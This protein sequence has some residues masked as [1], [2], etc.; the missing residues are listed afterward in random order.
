MSGLDIQPQN[1]RRAAKARAIAVQAD[2]A[3]RAHALLV[4]ELSGATLA[5]LL[6]LLLI[7]P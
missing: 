7:N 3:D 4:L 5:L 2:A 1:A 6:A